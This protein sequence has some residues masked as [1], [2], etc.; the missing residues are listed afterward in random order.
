VATTLCR[1]GLDARRLILTRSAPTIVD[2]NRAD[3]IGAILLRKPLV[4]EEVTETLAR[5]FTR[6]LP[7][8]TG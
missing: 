6:L 3:R 5:A 4:L 1:L 2:R 7:A 8:E